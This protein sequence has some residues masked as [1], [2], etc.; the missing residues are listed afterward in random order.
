MTVR[1]SNL[2]LNSSIKPAKSVLISS[3]WLT[4]TCT[5]ET[6]TAPFQ[7]KTQ[8]KVLHISFFFAWVGLYL[9]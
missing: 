9:K 2:L 3:Q 6:S 4:S 8:V 5:N 7:F 1:V